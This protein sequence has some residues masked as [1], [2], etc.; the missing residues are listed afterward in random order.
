MYGGCDEL[1]FKIVSENVS[2][3]R[4]L[5]VYDRKVQYPNQELVEKE[6]IK[7]ENHQILIPSAQKVGELAA[8][9]YEAWVV[10]DPYDLVPNYI[11]P[12]EL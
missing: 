3:S 2:Y 11:S 12:F 4:Y 8:K 10:K 1:N 6:L 9:N 7:K 5:T